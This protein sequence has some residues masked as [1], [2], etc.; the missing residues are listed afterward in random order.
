[1]EKYKIIT[2]YI[3]EE[4][5][6]NKIKEGDKLP[7]IRKLSEMFSCSKSTVIKSYDNMED[8]NLVYSVPRSGY[9]LVKEIKKDNLE[10]NNKIDFSNI[11]P[12]KNISPYNEFHKCIDAAMDIYKDV[13]FNSCNP[14]GLK[15]L[16]NTLRE[17][18]NEIQIFA[19]EE[20]IFIT[21]GSQQA[22]SILSKM[23]FFNNKNEILI[24][25]PTYHGILKTLK[26]NNVNYVTIDRKEEGIDLKILEDIFKKH[27]IKFFY[28]IPRL[29]NPTGFSYTTKMMKRILNLCE[30]YDVFIVEDDYLGDLITQKNSFSMYAL[31]MNDKVIYLKSFSKLLMPGLRIGAVILPKQ[32]SVEFEKCKKWNDLNTSI[33][34]QGALEI[35]IKS[36]LYNK[37]IK[38]IRNI[39]TDRMKKLKELSNNLQ[40]PELKWYIPSCSLFA[41]FY[42]NDSINLNNFVRSLYAKDVIMGNTSRCYSHNKFSRI[43]R[44]SVARAKDK[45]IEHGMKAITEYFNSLK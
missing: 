43:F 36:G 20:N 9:Y 5:K 16:I 4:I 19:R 10:F 45:D 37:H 15:N 39:Y 7:S 27:N 3:K 38:K 17:N 29:H 18:L 2:A 40:C 25:Q 6:N 31:D 23:N 33:L 26:L 28:T 22:I 42:L 21:N 24:E 11:S 14:H 13:F 34:T 35:Y 44:I 41:S 1:M 12:D 32:L 8:E 30:K